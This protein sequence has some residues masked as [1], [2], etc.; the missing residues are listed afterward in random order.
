ML[1]YV[2]AFTS[3]LAVP[4]APT[5]MFAEFAVRVA[6]EATVFAAPR[7]VTV[8]PDSDAV[9]VSDIGADPASEP[10]SNVRLW[11]VPALVLTVSVPPWIS[12]DVDGFA[13][14]RPR[15]VLVCDG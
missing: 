10:A 6:P 9:P 7:N 15:N 14:F 1:P 2:P 4:D 11:I 5:V 13:K 3:E 8:E 12:N